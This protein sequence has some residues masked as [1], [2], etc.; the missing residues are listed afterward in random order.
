MHVW[1]Q[2]GQVAY[3]LAQD[4]AQA[5]DA[6]RQSL[7]LCCESQ[8]AILAGRC[9]VG[10]GKIA[11]GQGDNQKATQ[12]LAAAQMCFDSQLRSLAPTEREDYAQ[13]LTTVRSQLDDHA[14]TAAW[15][16]G[17]AMSLEQAV[18]YALAG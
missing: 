5:E 12:L 6:Y 7:P 15:A 4:L 18:A 1:Y 2:R 8:N 17:Q 11:I 3:H 14:F 13:I 10:L 16:A 9:L